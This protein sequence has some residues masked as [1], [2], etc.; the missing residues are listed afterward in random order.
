M[1]EAAKDVVRA[2]NQLKLRKA[3]SQ[4]RFAG[5]GDVSAEAGE[6]PNWKYVQSLGP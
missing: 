3:G 2:V 1:R 4:G 6:S 5:E